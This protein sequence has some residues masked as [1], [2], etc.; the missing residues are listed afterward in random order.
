M[1]SD[2]AV[3]TISFGYWVQQRRLA[4]ELTRPE[5][6]RRVGC[7]PVTVKKI[8][9]DERRPSHQIAELLAD[10]LA[11]PD[12]DRDKFIRMARGEFV[13]P[14][15]PAP[16]L[17]S[18]PAF[19]RTHHEA[20]KWIDTPCVARERELDQLNRFL[21]AA[22]AGDGR[23]A[24]ISGEAG[25]GKTLLAREFARRA[26]EQHPHLIVAGG[27][28]N[29]HTGIGDPYLPFREI[30]ALFTGDIEARWAAGG[31]NRTAAQRLWGAV[32]HAVKAL[33]EVG[34]DLVDIF[35]SG[36]SLVTRATAA[37]PGNQKTLTH[38]K[39][40][41]AHHQTAPPLTHLQ[42][43][44]LFAQY[45]RVLHE[46]AYRDPLLV[47]LDDL[48]WADTGS[49]SL[50]FHLGR[51]LEGQRIL[52]VGLYRPAD[53]ALGR[54]SPGSSERERHPLEPV[55]NELQ[56]YSGDNHVV[57]RQSGG[58]KQLVEALLDIEP[59]RLGVDFRNALYRQTGG[60]PLFTVEML[61]GLQAR[62]SLVRDE[63]GRW[64]EGPVLDWT[65]LPSRVEGVINERISRLPQTLQEVLKIASV[66]GEVF[67]AEV[68]ARVQAINERQMVSQLSQI[69]DRQ[70]RLISVQDSQQ[71]EDKRLSRYRF[72]HSL[73]QK[74]IYDSLDQVER[75]YLHQAVG[76]TLEQLYGKNVDTV[77][78]QLA[79]HFAVCNDDRRS[80][81]YFSV[82]G[83]MAAAAYAYIEAEA[84]YSRALE[85]AQSLEAG[86][87][88]GATSEHLIHLYTQRGRTLELEARYNQALHNYAEMAQ[89]ALSR[90]DRAMELA[91]LRGQAIIRSTVNPA[92]DPGQGQ[93]LLE[94]ARTLARE[95][96]DH[97]AEAKIL[98]NLLLLS[99]YTGGDLHQRLEY[100]EQALRLAR[101]LNLRELMAFTLH[102]IF[103]AYAGAGQWLRA[104]QALYE[105]RDLWHELGNLPM[106]AETLMRIQWTYLVTGD[107]DQ[108]LTNSDEAF[109]IGRESN[110]LDAQALSRFVIG[111]VYLERGQ[112]DQAI[113]IMTEAVAVAESVE[114]LTPL[115]GTRADLGWLYG[116]LGNVDHGLELAQLAQTTAEAKLPILQSWSRAVLVNL[117][118]LKGDLAAAEAVRATLEPYQ[119]VKQKFGYMPFMWVRVALA[120]GEFAF[121]QQDYGRAAQVM[122]ELDADLRDAGIRYL[123]PDVLHLKARARLKQGL[124]P[125][126]EAYKML[127]RARTEAE[128][129]GSRRSLWPILVTLSE[130]ECQRGHP[131][132]AEARRNQAQE[133]VVDMA[134]HLPT[135]ELRA[136]F[137]NLAQVKALLSA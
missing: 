42:Q 41:V 97:A 18:L 16:K 113:V 36:P 21:K 45:T 124:P 11:I 60:H 70:Q 23:I 32:P 107:Y 129:L 19:L 44:D 64:I 125:I 98:W 13:D 49:I 115:T 63:Q 96:N 27:N 92:R 108:A 72:R 25:N 58:G 71:L 35:V 100:G 31:L 126:E 6:A 3:G 14:S 131:A 116:Q 10:Q 69:L 66:E 43:G 84:H 50:L 81:K 123:L 99:A 109:R 46:L 114:N 15:L 101:E 52:V 90:N 48:Q 12:P 78:P 37:A 82:A 89:L 65:I 132:E 104:R 127:V 28:C 133:I 87:G 75:V 55:I 73:F 76:T 24:F 121:S 56:R 130:I 105:A 128:A 83:D 134:H 94:K 117:Y 30:M 103:Y 26:Q 34:P 85:I 102:D 79:R 22:L 120:E 93:A 8:E 122:D 40:L 39:T 17:I 33:V 80:L 77:A 110:N 88:A 20:E 59:N 47:I 61:H 51:Q 119:A 136:A 53:V 118:L 54:L 91:A 67:T 111:F 68:A 106:L 29:A 86:A 5:L 112:P 74:F 1:D 4:L 7:S 57:L 62:G 9:R 95:L 135:P 137:L 38:L 2:E